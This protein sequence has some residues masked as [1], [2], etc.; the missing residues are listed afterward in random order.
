MSQAQVAKH[1]TRLTR[2][3]LTS[4]SGSCQIAVL[5]QLRPLG[6]ATGYQGHENNIAYSSW[7]ALCHF[8]ASSAWH[9]LP[10]NEPGPP[11]RR[12]LTL[13]ITSHLLTAFRR[14]LSCPIVQS[15]H[16][17]GESSHIGRLWS[18]R[19]CGVLGNPRE[20]RLS[21]LVAPTPNRN[22]PKLAIDWNK[23]VGGY[24]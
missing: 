17:S 14:S 3:V 2:G 4:L 15:M 8:P 9:R 18:A 6:V 7:V 22:F 21:G 10:E 5:S 13:P 24:V 23:T 16:F 12:L 1:S 11:H 19:D 20:A